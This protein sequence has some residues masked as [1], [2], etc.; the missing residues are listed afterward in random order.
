MIP[1]KLP[2][3]SGEVPNYVSIWANFIPMSGLSNL[4]FVKTQIPKH[5]KPVGSDLDN[6]ELNSVSQSE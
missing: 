3:P 6:D 5:S 1:F 4:S 2:S